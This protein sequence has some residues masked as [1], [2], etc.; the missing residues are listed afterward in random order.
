V[1]LIYYRILLRKMFMAVQFRSL[2]ESISERTTDTFGLS[3]DI[4]LIF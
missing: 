3:V 1:A 4:N 2:V